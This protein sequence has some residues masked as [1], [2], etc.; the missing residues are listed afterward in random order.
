MVVIV[1]RNV[2]R[3]IGG[4]KMEEVKNC[5][6]NYYCVINDP[7]YK[8]LESLLH[9]KERELE[10]MKSKVD[11][12][13]LTHTTREGLINVI[14][15]L[16]D[17]VERKEQELERE[18]HYSQRIQSQILNRHGE[19]FSNYVYSDPGTSLDLMAAEIKIL[20]VELE[21][22]RAEKEKL[23]KAVCLL[24]SMVLCGEMHSESSLQMVREALSPT[25]AIESNR[26]ED[27]KDE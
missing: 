11:I 2:A 13:E 9:Q 18:R 20:R 12:D 4:M 15:G 16:N 27:G 19:L 21:R 24:N 14:I 26:K 1:A 5:P 3:W 23:R 8:S 10:Q 17:W 7:R 25:P 6:H 22:E